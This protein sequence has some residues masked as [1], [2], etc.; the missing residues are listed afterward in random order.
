MVEQQPLRGSAPQGR[1]GERVPAG[2]GDPP[3]GRR[4]RPGRRFAP[5]QQDRH[6]GR[7]HLAGRMV[8]IAPGPVQQRQQLGGQYRFGV[9]NRLRRAQRIGIQF[10]VVADFDQKTDRVPPAE[11][12]PHPRARL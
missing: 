11:R 2:G 9:E 6:G 7:E 3:A 12:N 10:G 5:P 1:G 8:I 4:R